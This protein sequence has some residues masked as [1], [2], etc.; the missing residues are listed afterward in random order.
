MQR[1]NR[2]SR[3]KTAVNKVSAS[4]SP[5]YGASAPHLR[6]RYSKRLL[7]VRMLLSVFVE[8]MHGGGP[9]LSVFQLQ[10]MHNWKGSFQVASPSQLFSASSLVLMA[11]LFAAGLEHHRPHYLLCL[12]FGFTPPPPSFNGG[13]LLF[14]VRLCK[15]R[16]LFC[17]WWGIFKGA[18]EE[19]APL[20][21]TD[22]R[23]SFVAIIGS[24]Q[25]S[26]LIEFFCVICCHVPRHWD[27]ISYS[28][29]YFTMKR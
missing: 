26:T 29:K 22:W 16:R 23:S 4:P 13:C 7:K 18:L 8:E 6:S 3:D 20:S 15:S 1:G 19:W 24:P 14:S 2:A 27:A 12:G 9:R 10:A 17:V 28:F 25:L 11:L 21:G 5:D